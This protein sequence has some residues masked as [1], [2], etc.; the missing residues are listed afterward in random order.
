MS[1]VGELGGE[2]E[3]EDKILVKGE[4]R[5]KKIW[6]KGERRKRGKEKKGM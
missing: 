2:K 4:R 5:K 1:L 6:V 3:K